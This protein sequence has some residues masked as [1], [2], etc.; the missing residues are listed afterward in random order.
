MHNKLRNC[1]L[2][3]SH[4]ISV[5]VKFDKIPVS[6]LGK[7]RKI[8]TQA[9]LWF[10]F[11]TCNHITRIARLTAYVRRGEIPGERQKFSNNNNRNHLS[12][13]CERKDR[14]P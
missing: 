10:S 7:V 14:F 12:S 1:D 4:F 3:F 9:P 2:L 11:K 5:N 13:G 6:I 8:A